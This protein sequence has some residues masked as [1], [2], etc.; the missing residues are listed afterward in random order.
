MLVVKARPSTVLTT[1]DDLGREDEVRD[2][3]SHNSLQTW[4]LHVSLL[5]ARVKS[6]HSR[7]M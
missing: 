4:A 2:Y 6:Q 1:V 7:P 5:C 3:F